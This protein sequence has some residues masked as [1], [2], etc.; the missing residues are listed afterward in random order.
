MSSQPRYVITGATGHL[1]HLVV[2][3]LLDRGVPADRIVATGRDLAK[4]ADLAERGVATAAVDLDRPDTLAEVL[5]EGDVFLLVSTD[6]LEHRRQHQA[7]AVAVAGKA[8][9]ARIAYTSA[10]RADATTLAVAPDHAAT[11]AEVRDSGLPF[12]IFRN[13]WYVENLAGDFAAA[14]QT[15]VLA[16]AAGDGRTA[17]AARA[18]YA[19]AIAGGLLLDEPGDATYELGGPTAVTHADVAAAF[20]E[21]LGRDVVHVAQTPAERVAA[22]TAAGLD[23]D[24]A[25][26]VAALDGNIRDGELDVVTDDLA[27]LA[28]RP[29]TDL[30]QSVRGLAATGR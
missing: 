5:R 15:G 25:G 30:V 10:P 16:S 22:L 21:V 9:V 14:A 23:E 18:D 2:E 27:R 4:V 3:E 6:A 7:D 20:A 28:G 17:Y 24:T 11:E 29:A 8:G 26:F 1:G 13:N 19:A 12:Q